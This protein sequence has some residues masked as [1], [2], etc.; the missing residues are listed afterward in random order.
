MNETFT[1]NY[2][3]DIDSFDFSDQTCL[4]LYGNIK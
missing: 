2:R 1:V 4:C 3:K